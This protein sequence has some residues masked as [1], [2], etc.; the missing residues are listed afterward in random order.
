LQASTAPNL[1]SLI[2]TQVV[3]QF[4]FITPSIIR[5]AGTAIASYNPTAAWNLNALY[6]REKQS[7][8]R[9]I[10][11]IMNTSPSATSG[12]GV[13]L[14]EPINYYN[15]LVRVGTE[16]GKRSW[17]FQAAYIGSFLENHTGVLIWDNPFRLTNETV[18]NPLS[19]RMD[20]YPSNHANYLSFAGATDVSKYLRF[21]ASITPG[22]LRQN[23]PFIPYSTNTAIDPAITPG[24]T[25]CGDGTQACTSLAALPVPSLS[26]AKQTLAMNR[27]PRCGRKSGDGYRQGEQD[28]R[29]WLGGYP[30]AERRRPAGDNYQG[31]GQ[32][33]SLR[34][35]PEAGT[36]KRPRHLHP[37]LRKK[38]VTMRALMIQSP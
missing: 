32:D 25:A 28:A 20:L 35:K 34:K 37:R 19:G 23:D 38:N 21:M 24:I 5:K 22:W 15:N 6:W 9:P 27:L 3:S 4:N 30:E 13:E 18:S 2:N 8:V 17:A 10:G 36:D 14:P 16:Y 29:S 11:L 26:G 1:P 7:G 31:Q 12:F 33:A